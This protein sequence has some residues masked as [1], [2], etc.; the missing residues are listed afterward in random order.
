M[1]A[2]HEILEALE[3][4]H[5]LTREQGGQ[6]AALNARGVNGEQMMAAARR[7]IGALV[8]IEDLDVS[9]RDKL[10][11]VLTTTYVSGVLDGLAL[12]REVDEG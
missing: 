11:D 9:T 2:A 7:A 10:T 6:E 1:L 8:S 4:G 12:G 5:A 3:R